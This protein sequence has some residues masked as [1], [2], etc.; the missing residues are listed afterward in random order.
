MNTV[1]DVLVSKNKI[2]ADTRSAL[3]KYCKRWAVSEIVSVIETSIM[4]DDEIRDQLGEV[5]SLPIVASLDYVIQKIAPDVAISFEDARKYLIFPMATDKGKEK[6]PIIWGADPWL[7][8]KFFE[9]SKL[10]YDELWIASRRDI[11]EAIECYY[12]IEDQIN[13][14]INSGKNIF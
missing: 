6:V 9:R 12:P 5:Y 8:E 2:T 14:K 4:S 11:M 10:P 3:E 1:F 13:E 7:A